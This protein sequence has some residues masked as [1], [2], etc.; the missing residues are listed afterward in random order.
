MLK[1]AKLIGEGGGEFVIPQNFARRLSSHPR[2]SSVPSHLY[3]KHT[4]VG[5]LLNTLHAVK[6]FFH[7]LHCVLSACTA[8]WGP[9]QKG[10]LIFRKGNGCCV[11]FPTAGG[12]SGLCM[13][14]TQ[15][16]LFGKA[17]YIYI[18]LYVRKAVNQ[19][20]LIVGLK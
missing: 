19:N 9:L 15:Y 4:S 14:F 12:S 13:S 16:R 17:K 11:T 3:R 7:S 18:Y 6:L 2:F 5:Q 20:A 10:Y 1:H 8:K